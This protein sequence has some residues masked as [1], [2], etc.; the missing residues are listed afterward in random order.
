MNELRVC[1]VERNA[2]IDFTVDSNFGEEKEEGDD[3]DVVP[4]KITIS[5]RV[6]V[7]T[8]MTDSFYLAG[9]GENGRVRL[10]PLSLSSFPPASRRHTVKIRARSRL[11]L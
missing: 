1:V 4:S 7:D 11:E 5:R 9:P 10:F 2:A 6:H 3:D 8:P